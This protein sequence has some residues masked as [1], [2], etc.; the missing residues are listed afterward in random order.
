MHFKWFCQNSTKVITIQAS[1]IAENWT[2]HEK[3]ADPF[4]AILFY[5]LFL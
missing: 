2:A 3:Y 4:K 5:G 1:K